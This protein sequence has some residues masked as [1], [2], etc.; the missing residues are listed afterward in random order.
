MSTACHVLGLLID[1]IS[2]LPHDFHF[3]Q[4]NQDYA[5]NNWSLKFENY[6]L[7]DSFTFEE[8]CKY[9]SIS[10]NKIPVQV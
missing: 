10:M 9:S 8:K 7:D 5:Q 3:D 1:N 6:P 4:E 2:N